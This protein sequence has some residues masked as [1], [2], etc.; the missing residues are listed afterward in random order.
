[1]AL[2]EGPGFHCYLHDFDTNDVAEWNFHCTT[3]EGHYEMG[4]TIC[5]TCGNQIEFTNLPFHPLL[6]DG[7]KGIA[8]KCEDCETKTTGKVKRMTIKK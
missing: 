3:A 5:I 4:T 7:S 8:L 6:P 2:I 1:M